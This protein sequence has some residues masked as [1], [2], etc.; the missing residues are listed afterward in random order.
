MPH[1][2]PTCTTHHEACACREARFKRMRDV[3]EK[4]AAWKNEPVV[5]EKMVDVSWARLQQEASEVLREG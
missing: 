5:T 3:L 4:V 2:D 1:V